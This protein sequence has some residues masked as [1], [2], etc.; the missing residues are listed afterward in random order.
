VGWTRGSS[1]L[2]TV[3][4][5]WTGRRYAQATLRSTA[6]A[7]GGGEELTMRSVLWQRRGAVERPAGEELMAGPGLPSVEEMVPRRPRDRAADQ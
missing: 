6:G 2:D 1:G 3:A 5:D 7:H 4:V